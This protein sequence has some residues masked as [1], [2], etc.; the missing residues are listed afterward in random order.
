MKV[1]CALIAVILLALLGPVLPVAAQ[2]EHLVLAFYYNW[3][4]EKSFGAKKTSDQPVTPYKSADRATIERHI[5][6]AKQAGLD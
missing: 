6:Q 1:R 2:G 5:D 4:D 3:Y